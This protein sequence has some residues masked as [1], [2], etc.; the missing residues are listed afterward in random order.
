VA[1]AVLNERSNDPL[2]AHRTAEDLQAELDRKEEGQLQR[3]VTLL[4]RPVR[5]VRGQ[6]VSAAVDESL[7]EAEEE[8]ALHAAAQAAA[9]HIR[10]DMSIPEFLQVAVKLEEPVTQFFDNVFVMAKDER[11]RS[12]RIALLQQ[13]AAFTDGIVDLREL[14]G[15]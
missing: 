7:F 14:P 4:S 13:L 6:A 12:N 1:R 9:S 11:V 2:L 8:R 10:S 3:V 15:F 5:I